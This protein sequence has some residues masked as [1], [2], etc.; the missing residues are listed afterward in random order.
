MKSIVVGI[1]VD[2]VLADLGGGVI[3]ILNTEWGLSLTHAD[4]D[5]WDFFAGI[6]GGRPAMLDMMTRAWIEGRVRPE[7]SRLSHTIARLEDPRIHR[8]IITARGR[9]S[10]PA[11]VQ[12]LHDHRIGYESIT[13]DSEINKLEY[14]LDILID[15]RPTFIEE[16]VEHPDKF[17][18]VRDQKWNQG[19]TLP[20]NALRVYSVAEA[21]DHI[22][23]NMV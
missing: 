4:I 5:S 21:V 10:H 7:E 8:M 12:W 3:E 22:L 17:L 18:Y 19:I 14:P 16:V 11:V 9:Q 23:A 20:E 15:D 2:S 6:V 1:D 13:L